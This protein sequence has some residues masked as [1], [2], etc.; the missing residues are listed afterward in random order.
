MKNLLVSA[1]CVLSLVCFAADKPAEKPA[2]KSAAKP[3]W[4]QKMQELSQAM[5]D[6]LPELTSQKPTTNPKTIAKI[7]AATAKLQGLAHS[8]N[9]TDGKPSPTPPDDD[10]SIAFLSALFE[11]ELKHA[12]SSLN[13]GNL[14]YAKGSL[15]VITNYCI[16][17]HTRT[18]QGP[19]FPAF[20][21]PSNTAKL[22]KFEKAQLYA[23]TRQFDRAAKEFE[24]VISDPSFAKK[25]QLDWG[26]AVRQAFT[27]AVRVKRDPDLAMDIVN[28]VEKLRP[29]PP[30]FKEYVPAWKQS[31][32]QWK[33]EKTKDFAT[34][35]EMYA[36]AQRLLAAATKL[37]KYPL[38]HSADILFLRISLISHA[39]LG[40]Y[41][42]GA[43][44]SEAFFFAGQAY[45]LLD[46]H[47]VSP[48]PEM[49]YEACIRNTPHTD[50]ASQ[51]Y[52]RY[53]ANVNFGYT[54]SGGTSIPEDLK[55][56]LTELK[57]LATTTNKSGKTDKKT[58]S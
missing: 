20:P 39:I 15:R 43:H 16:A 5:S 13:S 3:S 35:A 44:A 58:E 53:E 27:I 2:D 49:Y 29:I 50:V 11:R 40:K 38:D 21:M 31:I 42:K 19:N 7:K 48:L 26:R 57:G 12:N 4:S 46:D 17:C 41:P 23:A 14:E 51:C 37:Q 45:D 36:E 24:S 25:N 56:L 28:K 1:S 52:K 8:I 30:L 55:E 32:Q 47:L 34:E 18:D 6:L 22:P 9:L 54:G 33:E 10:P